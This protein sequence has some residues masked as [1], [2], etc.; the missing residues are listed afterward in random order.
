[1][2]TKQFQEKVEDFQDILQEDEVD[3]FIAFVRFAASCNTK[4][5]SQEHL[6]QSGPAEF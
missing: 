3:E 5:I 2:I 4:V 1:M 6:Q